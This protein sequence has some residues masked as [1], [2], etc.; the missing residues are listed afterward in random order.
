MIAALSAERKIVD[1]D[2]LFFKVTESNFGLILALLAILT[3]NIVCITFRF[4]C[5]FRLYIVGDETYMI[6]TYQVFSRLC[7]SNIDLLSHF[8]ATMPLNI[9]DIKLSTVE[10]SCGDHE[11]HLISPLNIADSKLGTM[12]FVQETT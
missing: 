1:H 5:C 12:E 11:F 7:G 8:S 10:L 3:L 2:L 4:I 6:L 9:A